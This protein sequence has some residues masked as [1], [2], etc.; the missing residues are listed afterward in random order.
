MKKM[1]VFTFLLILST[2]G[3]A[4]AGDAEDVKASIRALYAAMNR[5]DVGEWAK[6]VSPEGSAF[7]RD[8]GLLDQRRGL[9][10]ARGALERN[11]EAGVQ[12]DLAIHHLDVRIYG[13]AA[14]ATFYRSG[15]ATGPDGT[16]L[17]GGIYRV[18]VIMLKEGGRWKQ[19][20]RHL[21]PLSLE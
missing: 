17:F 4:R 5:G 13:G 14:L 18:S 21:S 6:G 20:H 8:G 2:G 3:W 7:A 1:V 19:V 10:G 16:R 11:L 12:Y 9:Q 15:S